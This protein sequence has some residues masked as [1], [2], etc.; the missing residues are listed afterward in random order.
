MDDGDRRPGRSNEIKDVSETTYVF[1][2]Q[3]GRV[4]EVDVRLRGAVNEQQPAGRP[5]GIGL[6]GDARGYS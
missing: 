4:V 6:D 1:E 2:G 5:V 3:V